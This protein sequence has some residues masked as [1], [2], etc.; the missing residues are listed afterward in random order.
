MIAASAC[1]SNHRP[2]PRARQ[3]RVGPL[4]RSG[5]RRSIDFVRTRYDV[6]AT[7]RSVDRVDLAGSRSVWKGLG[8]ALVAAGALWAIVGAE[9]VVADVLLSWRHHRWDAIAR[10]IRE[11]GAFYDVPGVLAVAAGA[12]I[13]LLIGRGRAS[14]RKP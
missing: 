7:E 2:P 14:R 8:W 4:T 10:S 11:N 5:G 12:L 3:G 6:R 1:P 13:V 9:N